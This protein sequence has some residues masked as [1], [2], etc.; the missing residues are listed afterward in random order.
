MA[1]TSGLKYVVYTTTIYILGSE[2]KEHQ[3]YAMFIYQITYLGGKK[4]DQSEKFFLGK[5]TKTDLELTCL[6][7]KKN[8]EKLLSFRTRIYKRKQTFLI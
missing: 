1:H 4:C 7:K 5:R 6:K 3:K 2:R 8:F